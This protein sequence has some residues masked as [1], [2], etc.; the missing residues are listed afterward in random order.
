MFKLLPIGGM[1]M[2]PERWTLTYEIMLLSSAFYTG[3]IEMMK[4][5]QYKRGRRVVRFGMS[6]QPHQKL[7]IYVKPRSKGLRYTQL[8]YIGRTLHYKL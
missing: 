1:L 6:Y 8:K 7:N 5:V 2:A 3:S 4:S